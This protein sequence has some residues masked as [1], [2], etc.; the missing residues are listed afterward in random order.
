MQ[1]KY[2]FIATNIN[3]YS[4]IKYGSLARQALVVGSNLNLSITSWIV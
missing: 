1:G 3:N 2:K 4:L